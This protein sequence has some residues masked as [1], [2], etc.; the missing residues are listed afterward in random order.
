MVNLNKMYDGVVNSPETY[1]TQNL[2]ADATIIYVADS[3][4]FGSLPNLA[5]IG[6]DQ[7]AETILIKSKRS[8]G[9][10]EV[11]RALEGPA[12]RW[13]KTTAIARNF[14]NFDYQQIKDN[15]EKLNTGK[16]DSLTAGSNIKIT[17]GRISAT[18]TKYNDTQI[19]KDIAE[20][21]N[22]QLS[23]ASQTEAESGANNTKYM[24]PQAT[25]QAIE[26]LSTNFTKLSQLEEDSTHRTVTDSEK[27]SWNKKFELPQGKKNQVLTKTTDGAEFKEI[28]SSRSATFVIANYDSSENSKAGADYVIQESDCAAEVING[29]IT[30]LPEYG[31]K[32]QLTEGNFNIKKNLAISFTKNNVIIEG[33]GN[34]TNIID[35]LPKDERNSVI[36]NISTGIENC[37]L[38]DLNITHNTSNSINIRG[39][40]NYIKNVNIINN[41]TYPSLIINDNTS[42]NILENCSV[43]SSSYCYWIKKT[44]ENNH[45]LN[46]EAISSKDVL[47]HIEG[48]NNILSDCSGE[49]VS[50][51]LFNIVGNYNRLLNCSG[52]YDETREDNY[53]A[54]AFNISG[55][56][57]KLFNCSG[58]SNGKEII[59]IEGNNN[60][61]LNFYGYINK[62]SI[63]NVRGNDNQTTNCIFQSNDQSY[64]PVGISG[65]NNLLIGCSIVSQKLPIIV[66]GSKHI[67]VNNFT[68]KEIEDHSNNSIISN[69]IVK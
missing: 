39:N 8:D 50:R 20:L 29:F 19:K 53:V 64:Y 44:S 24:T 59:E 38:S 2:A 35:K 12:K 46:C 25:K 41:G 36:V 16:Q 21:Q 55:N 10:L 67:V 66:Y 42:E 37:R 28:S 26:K 60:Q 3:S 31:G 7:N 11:Q 17:N 57:N 14:T 30:K 48:S 40:K 22:S 51:N 1:L 27:Q 63:C 49:G 32:I 65:T 6:T 54:E 62:Y 47:F 9:G 15:I 18:D 43:E 45:L 4:V 5:V 56:Y 52:N 61:L 34:A 58:K 69:N 13:E 68:H 23:K 33:Y